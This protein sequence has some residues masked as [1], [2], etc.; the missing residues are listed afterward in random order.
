MPYSDFTLKKVKENLGI[1]VVEDQE[2]YSSIG[3]VGISA[4]LVEMLKYNVPLAFQE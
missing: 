2:L 3:A 1:R 4:Y